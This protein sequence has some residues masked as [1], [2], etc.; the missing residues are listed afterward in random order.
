M[1]PGHT[2]TKEKIWNGFPNMSEFRFSKWIWNWGVGG[3][4]INLGQLTVSQGQRYPP[5]MKGKCSSKLFSHFFPSL[6]TDLFN[7][8][9]WPPYAGIILG[10]EDTEPSDSPHET[11]I[12]IREI[13]NKQVMKY[14]YHIMGSDAAVSGYGNVLGRW[15]DWWKQT[16][17]IVTILVLIKASWRSLPL[18]FR[19]EPGFCLTPSV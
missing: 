15:W 12:V 4:K 19:L 17:E 3:K 18:L 13:V 6:G 2:A 1:G 16:L 11:Y 9:E 5:K 7:K 10:A 8:H 14:I